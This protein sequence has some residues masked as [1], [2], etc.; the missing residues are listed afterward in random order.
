M[1]LSGRVLQI[2]N[3]SVNDG[4]GIR[5]T[6]FLAGCPLRCKWCSNPE[7]WISKNKIA[8]YENTC[9][10]CGKCV[11]ACPLSIGINLNLKENRDR[12][13]ACGKCVD[14][15]VKGARK[16]MVLDMTSQEVVNSI[17]PYTIFYRSSG[18]GVTFSG[19]EAFS[20]S[21]FLF[22]TAKK[23]YDMGINLAVETSGYFDFEKVKHIFELFDTIFIDI[24]HMNN[25]KHLYYT[26]KD[27]ICILENIKRIYDINKNIVIRIPTI[28]GINADELNIK[29]TAQFVH[30][31]IP[32]AKIELLP[33]HNYG[34]VKYEALG[35]K[36]SDDLFKTPNSEMIKELRNLIEDEG[37]DT[38]EYK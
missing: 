8:W 17:K 12:C 22:E 32:K 37:V 28:V 6:V 24:K 34:E 19:G 11:E 10:G 20:Q 1:S 14:V 18:G 15:C 27:N 29:A 7:G 30:N 9:T 23:L 3:F 25:D 2:Q 4:D 31:S 35:F 21:E 26:G 33:Y 16:N 38:I 36:Y 5:S 13:N